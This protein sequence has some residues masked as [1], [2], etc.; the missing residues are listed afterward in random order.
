ML[1]N[2]WETIN[3]PV[4]H[5]IEVLNAANQINVLDGLIMFLLEH[6]GPNQDG[7][8]PMPDE[9][10]LFNLHHA[11]TLFLLAEPGCYRNIEV[12]VEKTGTGELIYQ[13][14]PWQYVLGA[15]Q[16]F[17]R[18]LSSL[19]SADDPLAPA[20]Y[21]LWRINWIHPFRNGNGRTAR[22]FSY[23]CL[24]LKVGV[25]LPGRMTVVDLIMANRERYEKSLRSADLSLEKTRM[26]D[27]QPMREF[28]F[29]LLQQQIAS[30]SDEPPKVE[31]APP[32]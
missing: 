23:A 29:D 4:A 3:G 31:T 11:G 26:P 24:C 21:A 28:L 7:R 2:N 32:A 10:A 19:W 6:R 14:P 18:D 13:P 15:M 25:Q 30:V 16:H 9:A 22:A 8:P 12:R 20:A 5:Q 1:D 27:L 17:F